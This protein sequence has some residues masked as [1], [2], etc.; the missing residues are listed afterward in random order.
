MMLHK[1]PHG[2]HWDW[3]TWK[4]GKALE[5]Y[6]NTG[7]IRKNYTG[8]L[9]KNNTGKVREICHLVIAKTLQIW[10]RT[11]NKKKFFFKSWKSVKSTLYCKSQG[12]LSVRKSG[13]QA[14]NWWF[15]WK[16]F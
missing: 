9:K 16:N 3:K 6:S 12:N 5:F 10:Y 13:N 1:T 2:S 4:N 11:L 7:K 14:P 8:K 15:E